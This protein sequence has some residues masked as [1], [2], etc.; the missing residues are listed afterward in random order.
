MIDDINDEVSCNRIN[1]RIY[2]SVVLIEPTLLGNLIQL[3]LVMLTESGN[4]WSLPMV[5]NYYNIAQHTLYPI[6]VVCF[7]V[8]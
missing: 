1:L 7:V 8:F 4:D 3:L 5:N 6:T 2:M